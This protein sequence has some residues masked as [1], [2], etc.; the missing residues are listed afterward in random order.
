MLCYIVVLGSRCYVVLVVI[1]LCWL[2]VCYVVLGLMLRY[3]GC[4][5]VLGVWLYVVLGVMLLCW[6]VGCYTGCYFVLAVR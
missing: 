3:V 4:Y 6:A 1:L 2:L 5:V